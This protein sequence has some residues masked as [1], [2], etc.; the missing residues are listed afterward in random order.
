M[1]IAIDYD[2]TYNKDPQVFSKIIDLLKS[3]GHDVICVTMRYK[4]DIDLAMKT[5]IGKKCQIITTGRKAKKLFV[6]KIGIHPDIW[7]DNDPCFLF[8]NAMSTSL[9]P[10][11][12]DV[13]SNSALQTED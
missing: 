10:G 8:K 7:I 2:G 1:L 6:E 5:S 13:L 9:Y 11:F 3:A 12:G 4:L